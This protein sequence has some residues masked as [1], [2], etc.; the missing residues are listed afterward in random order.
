MNKLWYSLFDRSEFKGEMPYFVD[1]SSTEYAKKL[2]HD[3][4]LI[5]DELVAYLKKKELTTYFNTTMVEQKDT[6]KTL[7]L[8]SWDIEMYENYQH[9]P[10]TTAIIKCFPEIVSAS[11]TMLSANSKIIPHCG[12]TNGIYRCH[13]GLIIPAAMPLCGFRVGDEWRS[14]EEGKLLSFIDANNHEA[15]N[16]SGQDRFIFLIDVIRPE[17]LHK[18]KMICATVRTSLFMQK[19]AEKVPVLY[20]MPLGLQMI[21]AKCLIPA[22]AIAI[23]VRNLLYRK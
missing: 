17:F 5:R 3:F 1:N 7:S 2:E 11:F 4:S 23:P 9:F 18:K 20:R 13:L 12:D 15:I 10:K 16:L 21:I 6:W 22:A 19:I 8:N 14:W